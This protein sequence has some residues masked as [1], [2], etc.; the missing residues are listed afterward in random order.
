MRLT[1][2]TL[3]IL[4]LATS[5][6]TFADD[7][8]APKGDEKKT[9]TFATDILPFLKAHCFHCHGTEDGK[10]KADLSLI[11][12]TDDLSVQQDRKVW[13]NVIHM[14]QNGEMPP[15]ERQRPPAADIEAAIQSIE[16][17]LAN[18]DCTEK[19]NV[20]RVTL[21]RLNRAEYNNTIRDLLRRRF[22]AGRRL[23]QR[24]RRLRLRQHR[25]R[26]LHHAAAAWKLPRRRRNRLQK[27]IVIPETVQP[28]DVRLARPPR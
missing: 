23:S 5:T 11:K 17:V 19:P 10:D 28:K 18:F 4:F 2:L 9:P 14:L 15:M 20:G 25:R 26:A 22:P 13:D 3:P 8:A 7:P 27:A 21:R 6:L 12:Y 24:R 16:G 1:S